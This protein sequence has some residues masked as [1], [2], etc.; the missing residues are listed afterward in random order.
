MR[1]TVIGVFVL[2]SLFGLAGVAS[3]D[4]NNNPSNSCTIAVACIPVNVP[5]LPIDVGGILSPRT[6]LPAIVPIV[7]VVPVV[8][9]VVPQSRHCPYRGQIR[10][11]KPAYLRMV[12]AVLATDLREVNVEGTM[13][14]RPSGPV[15]RQ[16]PLDVRITVPPAAHT[17]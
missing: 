13:A 16:W 12:A 4:V 10:T 17:A 9:V 6:V 5:V 1:S 8:P 14:V 7:P 11:S 2:A 15:T 3:A